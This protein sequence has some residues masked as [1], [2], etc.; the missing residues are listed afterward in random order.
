M[1]NNAGNCYNEGANDNYSEIQSKLYKTKPLINKKRTVIPVEEINEMEGK[2]ETKTLRSGRIVKGINRKNKIEMGEIRYP[3]G[4][5]YNGKI[6]EGMAN[7]KGV[8]K[9]NNG[10]QYDGYFIRDKKEGSGTW[11]MANGNVYTGGFKNEKFNGKGTV[12]YKTGD[13]FEG[14]IIFLK[15]LIF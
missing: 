14:I 1:G 12:K 2:M 10:G 9:Y 7:G 3:N 8:M 11:R 4:N 6:L 5:I 15:I 13:F